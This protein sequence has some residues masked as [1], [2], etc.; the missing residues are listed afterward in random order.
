MCLTRRDREDTW[1][2]RRPFSIKDNRPGY[3]IW[4]DGNLVREREFAD[5]ARIVAQSQRRLLGSEPAQR[6]RRIVGRIGL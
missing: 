2:R 3:G 4:R 6:S 1:R 5:I